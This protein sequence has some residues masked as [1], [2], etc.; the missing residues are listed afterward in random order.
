MQDGG[1][2]VSLVVSLQLPG[3][4]ITH[5]AVDLGHHPHG[6]PDR[7]FLTM[8]PNQITD[9]SESCPDGFEER[10]I[11]RFEVS[12]SGDLSEVLGDQGGGSIHQV[13]PA[14]HQFVVG[15]PHEL[16]PGEVAVLVLGPGG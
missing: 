16:R 8:A 12:G 2:T 9:G 4:L 6:L 10:P 15:P 1:Q 5:V 3:R 7:L 13:A 14:G 11:V